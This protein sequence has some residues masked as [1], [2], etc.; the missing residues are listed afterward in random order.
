MNK[1]EDSQSLI[2]KLLVVSP[3]INNTLKRTVLIT[4]EQKKVR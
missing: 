1:K 3:F 2:G 4:A